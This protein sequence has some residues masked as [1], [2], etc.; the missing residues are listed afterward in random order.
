ME[1]FKGIFSGLKNTL[2]P[3]TVK[4]SDVSFSLPDEIP[5]E[6]KVDTT[7]ISFGSPVTINAGYTITG[8]NVPYPNSFSHHV[9]SPGYGGYQGVSL[10]LNQSLPEKKNKPLY[11]SIDEPFEP[12]W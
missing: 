2:F 9:Q 4:I 8:G 3:G 10:P 7:G 11:R 6:I 12:A 1:K 5:T